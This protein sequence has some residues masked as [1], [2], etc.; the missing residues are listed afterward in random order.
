ME[1]SESSH[2]CVGVILDRAVYLAMVTFVGPDRKDREFWRRLF[3]VEV[4]ERE[5]LQSTPVSLPSNSMPR[6]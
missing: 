1:P 3:I 5:V 2:L 4:P 6:N